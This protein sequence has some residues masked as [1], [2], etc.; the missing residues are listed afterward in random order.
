MCIFIYVT[1]NGPINNNSRAKKRRL[2]QNIEES[3]DT[4]RDIERTENADD[5]RIR[6]MG[7]TNASKQFSQLRN[8]V[9][10]TT[11]FGFCKKR[12]EW[13]QAAQLL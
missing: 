4:E 1:Q 11:F 10:A 2:V 5:I 3:N 7:K 6:N 13:F 12:L 8:R 9:R